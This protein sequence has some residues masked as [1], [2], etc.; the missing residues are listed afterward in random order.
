[1]GMVAKWLGLLLL[2]GVLAQLS[3]PVRSALDIQAGQSK[4]RRREAVRD[5]RSGN[6]QGYELCGKEW[7]CP[8][9]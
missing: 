8:H 1:M 3:D 9:R 2:P 5:T 7:G 6:V 4:F